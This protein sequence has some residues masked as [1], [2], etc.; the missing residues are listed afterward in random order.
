MFSTCSNFIEKFNKN[1]NII[2]QLK[3]TVPALFINAS[4]FSNTSF[5]VYFILGIL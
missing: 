3:I 2:E 1:H 5:I 4:I